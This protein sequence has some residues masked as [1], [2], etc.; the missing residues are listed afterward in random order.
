M[1][2]SMVWR[3]IVKDLYLYREIVVLAT[4]GGLASIVIGVDRDEGWNIGAILFVTS[5]VALGIFIGM[6]G[7]L[8]ERQEKSLLFVL[9]LPISPMQ[10]AAAKIVSALASFLAPWLIILLT[11]FVLLSIADGLGRVPQILAMMGFFLANFCVLLALL[12]VTAS[13]KWAVAGIFL[14]NMSVSVYFMMVNSL[15]GIGD[16]TG[17][18]PVWT[19]TVLAVIATEAAV[20]IVAIALAFYLPSRKKDFI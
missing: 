6:Y 19:P 14:T 16:L 5:L 2:Q 15:R 13:E 17:A 10:Y 20:S 18:V 12:M 7:I 9:S 8:R 11:T 3:L 4:V 1:S